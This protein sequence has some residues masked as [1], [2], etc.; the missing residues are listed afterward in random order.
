MVPQAT[1]LLKRVADK[2]LSYN[3]QTEM[4]GTSLPLTHMFPWRRE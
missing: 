3:I 1:T 4:H 2:K